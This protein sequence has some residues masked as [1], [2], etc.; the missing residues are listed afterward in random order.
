M[1]PL[2]SALVDAGVLPL[3]D[4]ERIDRSL[5]PN[6]ARLHAEQLLTDAFLRGLT[7][8]QRRILAVVQEAQGFPTPPTLARLWAQED[9]LLWASVDDELRAV[10]TE[11]GVTA[12]IGASDPDMWLMVNEEVINAIDTWYTSDSVEAF[13][14]IP[15]LNS[16]ARSVVADA[17]ANWQL[18]DRAPGNFADGLPQLI[19]ELIPA[20][21]VERAR[22]IATTEA[23]RI[24]SIAEQ[25]AARANPFVEYL[26]YQTGEDEITCPVCLPANNTVTP[27]SSSTFPDGRGFPPRHP[28]CRCSVTSL[29]GPA[30]EA[31]LEQGLIEA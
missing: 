26:M 2:L 4:A 12:S 9:E 1:T 16:H 7:A 5:D 30:Y 27:K 10:A 19:N 24:F 21:G 23:T 15:N 28:N 11:Q 6:A 18:G 3:A 20:F 22:V 25:A 29:T 17:L 8:Q 14:S 31:L 13:G